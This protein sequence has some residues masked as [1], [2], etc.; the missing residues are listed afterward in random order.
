QAKDGTQT[1]YVTSPNHPDDVI[2]ALVEIPNKGI[3]VGTSAGVYLFRDNG[4]GPLR[5]AESVH[6][7]LS[8]VWSNREDKLYIGTETGPLTW[9]D[10][11]LAQP[12]PPL[13]DKP[14][15]KIMIGHTGNIW[16]G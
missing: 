13:D 1:Q 7:V 2:N 8:L 3:V 16:M 11:E 5:G 15:S 14:I 10:G 4:F 6:Q 12:F 9:Q